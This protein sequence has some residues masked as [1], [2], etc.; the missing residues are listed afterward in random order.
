MGVLSESD[1]RRPALTLAEPKT[2]HPEAGIKIERKGISVE[3]VGAEHCQI[4]MGES[5]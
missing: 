4:R 1:L 3:L 2:S 5:G